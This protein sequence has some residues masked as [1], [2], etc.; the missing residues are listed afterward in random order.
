MLCYTELTLAVRRL[1]G[2]PG[3]VA[4]RRVMS[5]IAFSAAGRLAS[6]LAKPASMRRFAMPRRA[7][8][9]R[10][11]ISRRSYRRLGL[12]HV[13]AARRRH[14]VG[15]PRSNCR[16]GFACGVSGHAPNGRRASCSS[17]ARARSAR[18]DRAGQ[19]RRCRGV[20]DSPSGAGVARRAQ[21]RR[22]AQPRRAS[23]LP[24]SARGS[25]RPRE[26]CAA[27]SSASAPPPCSSAR[28]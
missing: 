22:Q 20:A 28:W 3:R 1:T 12:G 15:D 7:A 18:R 10:R 27:V 19:G 14:L 9:A 24:Y 11:G 21:P 2:R 16:R 8:R 23:A 17:S 13:G 5:A 25:A 4:S 26:A 6:V